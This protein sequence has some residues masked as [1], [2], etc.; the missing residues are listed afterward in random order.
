MIES[1]SMGQSSG[2]PF[3]AD[4]LDSVDHET[5]TMYCCS[6]LSHHLDLCD[7]K[8]QQLLDEGKEHATKNAVTSLMKSWGSMFS[9]RNSH[10]KL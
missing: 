9:R 6:R 5:F 3:S 7:D 1:A 4:L 2:T 8:F 10:S